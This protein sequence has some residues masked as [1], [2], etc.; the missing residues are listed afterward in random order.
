M[1]DRVVQDVVILGGGTAGWLTALYAKNNLP[2]KKITVIESEAIGILGAGEGSTPHLVSL[3]DG[4]GIPVSKLIKETGSTIKNGIKFTNWNNGGLKDFYYHGFRGYRDLDYDLSCLNPHIS[5]TPSTIISAAVLDGTLRV[6]DF[7]ELISE[8]Y[9]VPFIPTGES[10][11]DP[12]SDRILDYYDVASFSIHFDASLLAETLKEIGLERGIN[13]VEGIVEEAIQDDTGD[14]KKLVLDTGESVSCDF[15]FDCSG[16]RRFFPK[17]FDSHWESYS[18]HLPVNAALAFALPI[19][20]DNIP[21]YTEAIAMKYGWMWKIPL[22][23]RYG[24]GYVFDESLISGEEAKKEIEEFFNIEIDSSR[25]LRFEPGHYLDPWKNNVVSIGLSSGFVEPLE[26]T[27]IWA[28]IFYMK[29]IL[30]N[31]DVMYSR[32]SRLAEDF[33]KR[34]CEINNQIASFVYFHYMSGRD[35]TSF[36]RHFTVDNAPDLLKEYLKILEYRLPRPRDVE[37]SVWDV[38]S[39]YKIALG[40]DY[41]KFRQHIVD[42]DFYNNFRHIAKSNYLHFKSTQ[43]QV[44]KLECVTHKEFIDHIKQDDEI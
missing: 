3:L 32:D 19:D 11:N 29:E 36:W 44:A 15:I 20:E 6:S 30:A 43:E 10:S 40:M 7:T 4:L 26:A 23:H 22:Q 21:A 5:S 39:W 8:A 42:T 9:K 14:V 31:P 27:S 18:K 1:S 37:N 12:D 41:P 33:N 28:S 24:C 2:T 13:L 25:I 38:Y 17:M 35:D 16:F 34:M